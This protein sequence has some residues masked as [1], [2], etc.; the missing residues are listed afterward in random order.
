MPVLEGK[1][2]NRSIAASN[3]PADPPMP[4]IGQTKPFGFEADVRRSDF[5]A[6]R[7]AFA[8]ARDAFFCA[9]RFAAMA[10]FLC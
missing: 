9:V 4:A 7:L 6:L 8:F 10:A 5:A 3:P 2:R 1:L